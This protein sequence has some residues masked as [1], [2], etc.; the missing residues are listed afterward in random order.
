MAVGRVIAIG[1]VIAATVMT[2]SGCQL[3]GK[4]GSSSN[5]A[6]MSLDSIV[7]GSVAA[8]SS[9]DHPERR[10]SGPTTNYA[11]SAVSLNKTEY[12]TGGPGSPQSPAGSKGSA[13]VN[14]DG[15]I[16]LNFVDAPIKEVVDVIIG[17]IL[18]E[19]YSIDDG[20]QG[21]VTTRTSSPLRRQDLIPIL[22]NLLALRGASL[23]QAQGVWHVLPVDE[24]SR[25]PNVVVTPERR[26]GA[27][28]QAVHIIRL[29][30]A[31]AE[32]VVNVVSAQIT[33]GRQLVADPDRNLVIFIGP[34]NEARV[35]EDMVSVL[36]VD[37]MSDKLFALMPVQA[38]PA[39]EVVED[40]EQVFDGNGRESIRF[41]PIDR[42]NAVLAIARQPGPLNEAQKW[43]SRF[44][45]TNSYA[46]T[47]AF[48]YY[49]HNGRA[50]ELAEILNELFYGKGAG[51]NG[52]VAP[53]LDMVEISAGSEDGGDGDDRR[54]SR[55][56]NGDQDGPR[57]VADERNN[58]LVITG[59]PEQYRKIE[60]ILSRLD[61][62]PLQV[63]I[64]VIICEVSLKGE[65]QHGV[66]WFFRAGDFRGI[67]TTKSKGHLTDGTPG[68]GI[69]F[70]SA[71]AS[72]VLT[73]LDAVTDI[74]IVSSPKLMVLDNQSARLQ[75]G[76]QVP[77]ATQSA[78][79]T[80][81]PG[82]P[83]V[84]SVT[85]VDT[86]VI[87]E[88]TPTVNTGGLVSLRIVQEVS[89]ATTTR[90]SDIDS[91]TIQT[92]KVES[93]LAVQ[94]GETVALAGLMDKRH[95]RGE[96]GVPVLKDIP[97]LGNLF[98][99]KVKKKDRT[100]LI[101]LI[102]PKVVRDP[103]EMRAVTNELKTRLHN[104]SRF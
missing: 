20:V 25:L 76:D 60:A 46:D 98:K 59:T 26:P 29:Y 41:V 48:V 44:D 34:T 91:P 37:S 35:I 61:I 6:P 9:A 18:E 71:N 33:P 28:G 104:V 55:R 10:L 8:P 47:Q 15:D 66:E 32:S 2:V 7:T 62:M 40:L 21:S 57:I 84:N 77:V 92:R 90:T 30:H 89:Q 101:V 96:S 39:A 75:V 99:T 63:L 11:D 43:V 86:G 16:T 100:E 88:V 24:A 56:R 42:L 83:I 14:D 70:E 53:G 65:L 12:Y 19:N 72:V 51:K 58:A 4:S 38:A 67:F 93:T 52:A 49:V 79:S 97:V 80:D 23:K 50:T 103:G 1:L 82:A 102:T 17:D 81:D 27:G 78:V 5:S 45:R 95:E 87:L 74:D 73:A 31:R 68:F 3:A 36:D 64:E 94:S 54:G 13:S 22:E 69:S 85:L